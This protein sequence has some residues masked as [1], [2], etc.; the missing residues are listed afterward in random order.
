MRLRMTD[1]RERR[2]DNLCEATDENTK[3]KALD[4]AATFYLKMAGDTTA[5]PNGA[6]VELMERAEEKGSLTPTE[7]A[8]I[9]D[10][11]ELP[12]KATMD[13]S[14]GQKERA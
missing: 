9:L 8:D 4:R 2:L 14:I 12:L 3:S 5:V 1:V 10:T 11:D 7:I 6:F 13:W